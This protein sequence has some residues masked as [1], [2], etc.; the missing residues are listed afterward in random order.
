MVGAGNDHSIRLFA[1]TE[2]GGR[3]AVVIYSLLITAKLNGLDPAA[4]L[5]ATLEKLPTW[6]TTGSM[7]S[8]RYVLMRKIQGV[9]AGR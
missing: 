7:N 4:W 2:R 5:K 8:C 3:Q 1:G 6:P 9:C